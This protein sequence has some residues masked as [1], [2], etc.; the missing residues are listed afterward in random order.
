ISG[1]VWIE[2]T[3]GSIVK[4]AFRSAAKFDLERDT[5]VFEDDDDL[6]N[7]PAI[8]KPF[9]LDITMIT[10]EYSYW[11]LRHW[12]PRAMRFEGSMRAGIVVAP[13]ALEVSYDVQDVVDDDSPAAADSS[14]QKTLVA[15]RNEVDSDVVRRRQNGRRIYLVVPEDEQSLLNSPDLP[16]PVWEST[17][18]FI[19]E[20]ELR[21]MYGGLAE[22][23]LPPSDGADVGVSWGLQRRDL[24]RYNR[25]EGLSVGA[26][27]EARF[28]ANT[29]AAIGRIGIADLAPNLELTA[30][31]E[32]LRRTLSLSASHGLVAIDSRMLGL[33]ASATAL[34]LGRDDG[35]Y[36]RAT[37][38]RASLAPP[39]TRQDW[40]RLT[41]FAE[42]HR[43]ANRE[44]SFS[45]PHLFNGRNDFR[46]NLT[47]DAAD[48]FGA[49]LLLKQWWG[50]DP[51]GWQGGIQLNLEG[52]DGDY[53]YGRGS[54]VSRIAFPL[55]PKLRAALE[56]GAGTSEGDLPTQKQF[57]LG[58]AHTLR[59]YGGSAAVGTSF[60]RARA[61]LA[62]TRPEVGISVF[63][64]AGWAGD[65][66]AIDGKESLLSV[67][68]GGTFL[69]GL[70]RI[71]LARAL[72]RHKA[73]RL[74]LYL[75]AIL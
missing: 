23:P 29:Y 46:P 33:G 39:T 72:R 47:A 42:R 64:D 36:Y 50:S 43:N 30:R 52:A 14:A 49:E 27:A 8:L 19:T 37:A 6:E 63:T 67:G 38:L 26:R 53:R 61:E 11:R 31:R 15:W 75:D 68:V 9:E 13:A 69:D 2:P 56:A 51:R 60:G 44:T 65:R 66:T 74:E 24:V 45:L 55:A 21:K 25:V 7:V 71:D 62:Y 28:S 35:D 10:V 40:I 70:M 48:L 58:G 20:K 16:P 17:P 32:T 22:L 5:D 59:G 57:F 3:S 34:L 41:A 18:E 54:L 73:W 12:L 1:S 4:A